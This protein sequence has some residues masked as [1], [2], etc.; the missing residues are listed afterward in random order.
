MAYS[1]G[2]NGIV[3]TLSMR[4]QIRSRQ[5]DVRLTCDGLWGPHR[6]DATANWM[7]QSEGSQ[8]L[9]CEYIIKVTRIR[10]RL[11]R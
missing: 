3:N 8:T 6:T 10:V 5:S 11:E 7:P 9:I 2:N 1:I 4:F